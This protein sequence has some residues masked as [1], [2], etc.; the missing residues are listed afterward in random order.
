MGRKS[1]LKQQRKQTA[2]AT[3]A[4]PARPPSAPSTL[5]RLLVAPWVLPSILVLAAVLRVA[6]IM[7]LRGTPFV[8]DLQLDHRYY[9]E[10]AQR[11]LAGDW[12]GGTR[13]FWV[14]P[15]YAYFLAGLYAVFGRSLVVVRIV[16]AVLGVWTCHLAGL[17]G[18]RVSGSFAVGNLSALLIAVFVPAVYYDGT[19]EKTTLCLVLFTGA[20]VL[21]YGTSPRTL[22]LSGVLMG[23]A[24]LTRGNLLLLVVLGALVLATDRAAIAPARRSLAFLAGALCIV[25]LATVRN[26]AVSGE[27]VPTTANFGQNLYIGQTCTEGDGSYACKFVRLDPLYEEGDF[28]DE[29]ERRLHRRLAAGEVSAYWRT[30]ALHTMAADPDGVVRRTWHNLRL[31]VHE[32][33]N[34]DNHNLDVQA[35]SSPVLRLPFL[36]M[37]QLFPLAALGAVV[38]WRRDRARR[39][40]AAAVVVYCASMLPLMVFARYRTTVLPCVAV[41]AATALLWLDAAVRDRDWRRVGMAAAVAVPVALFTLTW[42]D[43]MAKAHAKS[44][45]VSYHDMGEYYLAHGDED[46]AIRAFE[47]AVA[48]QPDVVIASMRRLGDLYR[49]R[50]QYDRAER[51]MLAVLARKPDSPLG[52]RALAQLYADM[53]ADDRYRDDP[54]VRTKLARARAAL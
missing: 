5:D 48:A 22:L 27:L 54:A 46:A 28:R 43:W 18:R 8:D 20:L 37:G 32:Y 14:D 44:M 23:L 13:P 24:V 51:Y 36:W 2:A 34:S 41:L 9:D 15:L 11:I 10:W 16:Q 42:P 25:G 19:L 52:R 7:F 21:F 33:E 31:F 50:K 40:L 35:E 12:S 49:V 1:K 26:V 4:R 39:L 45:A 17:L 30:E 53:A 3:V 29:A 6:N 38:S 47:R